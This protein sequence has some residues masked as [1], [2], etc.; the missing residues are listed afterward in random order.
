LKADV[1]RPKDVVEMLLDDRETDALKE[2]SS[3]LKTKRVKKLA[4]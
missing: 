3:F 4:H 2:R 1:F